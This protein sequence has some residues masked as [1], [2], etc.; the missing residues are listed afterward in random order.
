M[1]AVIAQL[2]F[3]LSVKNNSNELNSFYDYVELNLIFGFILYFFSAILYVYVLKKIDLSIAYPSIALSY[4]FILFLS[5]YF[6][7][8]PIT[9]FK[10]LGCALIIVGIFLIWR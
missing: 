2:L 3:K 6:F 5:N 7:D 4:I 10:I 1:L 9:I 8:E